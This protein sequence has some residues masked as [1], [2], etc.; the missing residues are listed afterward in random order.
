MPETRYVDAL[1]PDNWLAVTLDGGTRVSLAYGIKVAFD[2]RSGGRDSFTILEG[3]YKG[4]KA[5]VAQKSA[6]ESYLVSTISHLPAGR[7]QFDTKSQRLKFGTSGPYN[8]FSGAGTGVENGRS[9]TYT[10]VPPGSYLLAIPA[11]PSKQTRA[12]YGQW[13]R[14]HK[15]WFRIG[16]EHSGSRFL[17]AGEISDGCVTVRQFVSAFSASSPP[18]PSGFEDLAN[19]AGTPNQGLLGLPL[20]PQPAPAISFDRIY[21][22]LILRRLSDQAV[23][24]LLVTNN[25]S[26]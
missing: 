23:G 9:V 17:H 25:G 24:T 20:P 8:A 11:Y 21:D 22:Y 19:R 6:S 12:A 3:V 5:S 1:P 18:P 4:K 2:G 10:P 13:T 15:T 16:I 7:I 26:L 14:Y